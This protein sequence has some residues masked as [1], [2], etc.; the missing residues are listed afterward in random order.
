MARFDDLPDK[1]IV[2]IFSYLT[3]AEIRFSA[4]NVCNRWRKLSEDDEI[5]NHWSYC[6]T[7]SCSR[8]EITSILMN[9]PGLR[10]FTYN[11]TCNVIEKLSEYC[12]KLTLLHV[13][14]IKLSADVLKLTM[15]RLTE[16]SELSILISPTEEGLQIA[17][18][19]GQSETLVTL[20]LR[21]SGERD[22]MK[23]LLKPIADGCPNL[24][25]LRC[26]NFNCHNN[27]VCY[28]L[29]RKRR[30]LVEY[31]H[32]RLLST[33]LINAIKQ[34]TNLR[35]L[36]FT[37][38]YFDGPFYDVR[39]NMLLQNLKVFQVYF[40]SFEML[41]VLYLT[42]FHETLSQLSYI[43]ICFAPGNIDGLINKIILKCPLLKNLELQGNLELRCR[44]LK[45]I[46]SCK[47]IKYLDV[48][49]CIELGKKAMKFVAEGCPDLQHLDVSGI[50][51]SD[52]MFRQ[53]LRC[54]N[55][56]TLLM[57]DCDLSQI[58]LNLIPKNIPD[59]SYLYIGPHFQLRDEV[60]SDMKRQMPQLTIKKEPVL[61]ELSEYSHVKI[62][63]MQEYF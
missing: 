26:E 51:I 39:T 29:Q 46:S 11:G 30:Q 54:R 53:I 15:E 14:H 12:T 23:G 3:I 38:A 40:C 6:P 31:L 5:W 24:N 50:P 61:P 56:K 45:N 17:R 43:G 7:T 19:I 18:I 36:L 55:L 63:Y 21:S 62:K 37:E 32:Y 33:D 34:C 25:I 49:R 58:D 10:K 20:H 52:S 16:L 22:I 41:N 59:L 9:V 35:R 42:V 27:E 2:K 60:I 13:P 1:I 44:A 8:E 48:S 4:R 47:L 57:K 28:L